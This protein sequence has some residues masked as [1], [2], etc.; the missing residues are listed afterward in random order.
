MFQMCPGNF[1]L[2]RGTL[3]PF[4]CYLSSA[5]V[6]GGNSL[7]RLVKSPKEYEIKS[8]VWLNI[9][10]STFLMFSKSKISSSWSFLKMFCRCS[11]NSFAFLFGSYIIWLF[12]SFRYFAFR[13]FAFVR[14]R[15]WLV[16]LWSYFHQNS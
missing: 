8:G 12:S 6:I 11:L 3:S 16:M 4:I 9:L 14:N 13:F 7:F 10:R 2:A 15:Y 5:S 1:G